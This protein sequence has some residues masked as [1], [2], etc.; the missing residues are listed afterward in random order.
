MRVLTAL[1]VITQMSRTL[2]SSA[3]TNTGSE[4]FK[5]KM[6]KV[7]SKRYSI[8]HVVSWYSLWRT[9]ITVTVQTDLHEGLRYEA[10]QLCFCANHV[11]DLRP[12]CKWI[13]LK[14]KMEVIAILQ[15]SS[16][17]TALD[18]T[19]THCKRLGFFIPMWPC[20]KIKVIDEWYQTVQLPITVQSFKWIS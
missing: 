18:I 8:K 14:V 5:N 6:V 9:E 4:S 12:K 2:Y 19:I 15:D 11:S 3:F 7:E 13:G 20:M 17:V 10:W 1:F 16:A